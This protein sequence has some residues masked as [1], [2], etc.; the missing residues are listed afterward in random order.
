MPTNLI[1]RIR[2]DGAVTALVVALVAALVVSL[3][4]LVVVRHG[5]A[6]RRAI[7]SSEA[8]ALAAARTY[9]VDLTTYDYTHLDQDYAW[10]GDG[11]TASFAKQFRDANKPLR[12][13]IEQLKA[14]AKGTVSEA[15]ATAVT[16]ST[17]KV[18]VF[19][20]QSITNKSNKQTKTDHSRVVMTMVQRGGAWL[21]NDVQL[22]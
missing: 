13:I 7:D 12:T 16:T 10:V 4:V 21:V 11:A 8:A 20:D 3:V 6:N 19:I 18:L 9:A 14:T 15:A 2:D 5:A 1:R 17:V 22:R